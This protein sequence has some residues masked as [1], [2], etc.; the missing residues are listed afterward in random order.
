M[1]TSPFLLEWEGKLNFSATY[2][3]DLDLCELS[4]PPD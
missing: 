3:N 2:T 1:S 4:Q